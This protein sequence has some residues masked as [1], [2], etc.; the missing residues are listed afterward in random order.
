[1][2]ITV[3]GALLPVVVTLLMGVVAAWHHDFEAKQATVLNR[4]VMLYA[5]PM[6]LFAGMLA[7]PRHQLTGDA[8]L[9]AVIVIAMIMGF[10]V[11]LLIARFL[12]GRNL[13][14]S[15]LQALAI[16]APSVAF[17]GLPVLGYLFGHLAAT[18]PVAVSGLVLNVVQIP[19]C[20]ILLSIGAAQS[21]TARRDAANGKRKSGLDHVLSA[22]KQPVVRAPIL[23]LVILLVDFDIPA[24][25]RQSLVLLGKATGGA[26]LFA[27]GI[28]LYSRRIS[29]NLPVG[30]STAARNLVMPAAVWAALAIMGLPP[31]STEE[32]VLAMAIPT[33]S[34]CVILA[35]QFQAAEQEMASTLFFSTILS[36]PTM[37][38]FIRLMG[39]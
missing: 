28:I 35:V 39:G 13:M 32:A 30:V 25:I 36:L 24:V 21:D 33:S 15:A 14:T 6:L 29:F 8:R 19:A 16:G 38:V 34:V 26:A 3:I 2:L 9:A 31:E 20:M 27:S 18:I 7:I 17:V 4:M 11:P 23:A 22:L 5:L 37:G 10:F 1:M 12:C